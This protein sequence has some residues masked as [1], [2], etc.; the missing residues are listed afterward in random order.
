MT[1]EQYLDLKEDIKDLKNSMW[2]GFDAVNGRLREAETDIAI[3]NDRSDRESRT[4][5][6]W[7]GF[8]GSIG[9]FLGGLLSGWMSK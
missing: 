9:G 4:A 7:G 2:R 6:K 5:S 8:S 1:D 3:L